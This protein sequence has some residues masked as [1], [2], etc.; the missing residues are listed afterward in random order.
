MARRATR[1]VIR[2]Y[3]VCISPLFPPCCRFYPTCS[4]YAIEAINRF[5]VLRGLYLA[6]MRIARC[7]P[8]CHGGVDLVPETFVLAPW[9]HQDLDHTERAVS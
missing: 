1:S 7:H 8:F 3:Q 4:S 5:G 9:R 2:A 6:A